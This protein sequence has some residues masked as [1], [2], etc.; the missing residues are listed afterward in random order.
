MIIIFIFFIELNT[1]MAALDQGSFFDN[2]FLLNYFIVATSIALELTSLS[3][4]VQSLVGLLVI[5]CIWRFVRI[6]HWWVDR[7]HC[8]AGTPKDE[9][10][11]RSFAEELEDIL[12]QRELEIPETETIRLIK[13]ESDE[14]V[15]LSELQ[16]EHW[17]H[18][19]SSLLVAEQ[20]PKEEN[21]AAGQTQK[22]EIPSDGQ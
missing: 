17:H 22:E 14:I 3:S 20:P 8:W 7:G 10:L 11:L 9:V 21:P 16:K 6:G 15:L 1:S 5:G 4:N 12:R 2:F 19:H 13:N 18:N